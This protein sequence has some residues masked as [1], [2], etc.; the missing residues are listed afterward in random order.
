MSI[1]PDVGHH[2]A[3]RSRAVTAILG[4][5]NTGKTHLAI[6]RML[7]HESGVIGLP[8]RLLAREVYNRVV[9]RVGAEAV[10]L[11]TG[12]EK[13]KP[14]NPKY[15]VCTVEA[16][17]RDLDVAFVAIDEVQLAADLDRGHVFTDRILRRRGR[18][19]TLL[20]GAATM[21]PILTRMMPN[22]NVITRPRL[23]HLAYSG[24][25]KITR[26]PRRSAIVAFSADDVY[27]IAELV[28]RQRG[29][30]AVVLGA[31]SPRTRNAQVGLY[32]NGDVDFLVATDAIGM[33]LNLDV[34]HVAFAA[35]RKFDGW[36][37]RDLNPAEM[38]QV[39][40]RAGRHMRDGTFGVTGRVDP[41][42]DELVARL[43]S[44]DFEPVR[45]LQWRNTHLDFTSM[46]SL[47]ASLAATP[48]EDTL[49][50][51]P[52][53]DDV[54]A[55]EAVTRD[56]EIADIARGRDAVE[57]LWDVCQVPDYRK[58]AP[59]NHAE[60][61][62]T[63]YSQLMRYGRIDDDWFARQIGQCDRDD[64]DI[65]TLSNRIAHIRTWT[66]V[67]N[68]PEWLGD[69]AHWQE[70][71]RAV[72]D[73][74]S[75]A[76]HERLAQR[77]VDRR[78][79]VLARSLR[80]NPAMEAEI[81]ASGDV[82]VEGHHVGR[83]EGLR[84]TPDPEADGQH[85]KAI[86]AAARRTLTGEL[87]TRAERLAKDADEVIQLSLDGT[88]TWR[89]ATIGRVEKGDS[90][91]NPRVVLLA[92]EHLA[93]APRE[94]AEARLAKWIGDRISAH[95]GPLRALESDEAI[96]GMARGVA[97]QL[98]EAL[99][100][101]E[102]PR[103]ADE[104]KALSQ[105][106]RALLRKHGVRFGAHHV[107][108]PVLLKPGPRVLAAQLWALHHGGLHQPGFD[109][110]AALAQSGRMSV[111]VTPGTARSLYRAFGFRACGS[112]AV[113]IDILERIADLI[114]TALS[115]RPDGDAAPPPG[116]VDGR[117]FRISEQMTSLAGCAG[118]D[119]AEILKALGYRSE[120]RPAPA[121]PE[122]KAE[123]A[124]QTAIAGDEAPTPE[125]PVAETETATADEAA[126]EAAEPSAGTS[127]DAPQ[128]E[129][130]PDSAESEAP[131]SVAPAPLMAAPEVM[132]PATAPAEAE[133]TE[134]AATPTEVS[135][136]AKAE[137]PAA[138]PAETAAAPTTATEAE[139]AEPTEIVVWRPGRRPDAPRRRKPEQKSAKARQGDGKRPPRGEAKGRKGG[140]GDGRKGDR[141]SRPDGQPQGKR[142]PKEPDPLSPFAA[143]KDLRDTLTER[144]RSDA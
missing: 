96:A 107:Y 6:E 109:D 123:P 108:L 92:D 128:A 89:G 29:G 31:L 37:F 26:L 56:L 141:R 133:P 84:F 54:L 117:T 17:P 25:K 103:V 47:H 7:G 131:L 111:A 8:L 35:R 82:T 72:E 30:A 124:P 4:P 139:E 51:A 114:R 81:D 68:R 65:D 55:L 23:S 2:P 129:A 116:A 71:A 59:A 58:I 134:A 144:G 20:L 83:L 91:L 110:I 112:R 130:V 1:A 93:G 87:T 118:D 34:D 77:F 69:P 21:R 126:A 113:R 127:V 90:V 102:R 136:E 46:E 101:L 67:A 39:A 104:V 86:A 48:R 105:D 142:P 120:R 98:G 61:V 106:D 99:G 79:S 16:M 85:L 121:T 74:L 95:L 125:L 49:T 41:L 53:S 10:A 119:F 24:Q 15:W 32:Q 27:A 11:V 76:L 45:I 57:L 80:E 122:A 73:R 138:P 132:E 9:D 42:E 115:W 22:L 36:Q 12:E 60:L 50:R 44:H 43:E 18:E 13:I 143:L 33:G 135:D 38:G 100:V 52:A 28:R 19:E 88:F 70:R 40:G 62:A 140:R 78:T 63:L 75:D 14:E 137:T 64:G 94:N 66:F 5:T 97:F 3:A